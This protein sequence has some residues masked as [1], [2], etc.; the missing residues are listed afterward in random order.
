MLTLDDLTGQHT[1]TG[2]RKL[3]GAGSAV[4]AFY[5][6]FDAGQGGVEQIAN[7]TPTRYGSSGAFDDDSADDPPGASPASANYMDTGSSNNFYGYPGSAPSLA[8]GSND[9]T[10]AFYFAPTSDLFSSKWMM[11]LGNQGENNLGWGVKRLSTGRVAFEFSTTGSNSTDVS[12]LIVDTTAPTVNSANTWYHIA[13]ARMNNQL[14]IWVDG[15]P[16]TSVEFT[17]T[18]DTS[19]DAEGLIVGGRLF[20]GSPNNALTGYY[21]DVV[22][23]NGTAL[24]TPG[25]AF[26]KPTT[27]AY[28][29]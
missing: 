12:A 15:V 11:G 5:V 7:I 8:L 6:P 9:F 10:I 13:I 29:P 28:Q 21:D 3:G 2:K 24:Y 16:Q 14:G 20:S 1:L 19:D 23:Y 25:A 4:P 18:I 22:V 26:T 27:P 17:A